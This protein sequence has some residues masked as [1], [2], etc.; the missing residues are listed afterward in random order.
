[1]A[2]L[3]YKSIVLVGEIGSGKSTFAKYLNELTG[4]KIISFSFFLKE[5]LKELGREQ[6]RENLQNLGEEY[7]KDPSNLLDAI[8]N[9]DKLKDNFI[10]DGVRHASI[11]QL[12]KKKF[13]PIIIY[14]DCSLEV[15][16]ERCVRRLGSISFKQFS[17][18]SNHKVE[19]EIRELKKHADL[20]FDTDNLSIL[21][22]QNQIKQS[23]YN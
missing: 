12:I 14:F 18:E 10:F 16:F 11:L 21:E 23:I 1:M 8:L 13:S 17:N 15:R 22:I 7:V 9:R 6:T 3:S 20:V 19:E 4:T 5:R 2:G